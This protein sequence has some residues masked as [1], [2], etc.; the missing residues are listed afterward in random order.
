MRCWFHDWTRW[1]APYLPRE[2]Y[3][4]RNDRQKR[5]CTKCNKVEER[6]L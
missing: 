6:L 4:Y 2:G 1:S 3:M 5:T